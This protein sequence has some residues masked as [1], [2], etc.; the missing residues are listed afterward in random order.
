MATYRLKRSKKIPGRKPGFM[1]TNETNQITRCLF[2]QV[3]AALL[4]T[5]EVRS[6]SAGELQFVITLKCRMTVG[7]SFISN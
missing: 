4:I 6:T 7:I 1:K 2:S 5:A 3:A